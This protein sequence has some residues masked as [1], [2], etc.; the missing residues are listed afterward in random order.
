MC[1]SVFIVDFEQVRAGWEAKGGIDYRI[2]L[3]EFSASKW[4]YWKQSKWYQQKF[5]LIF[6]LKLCLL[7]CFTCLLRKLNQK[8]TVSKETIGFDVW[9]LIF[10]ATILSFIKSRSTTRR[11]IIGY[12]IPRHCSWCTNDS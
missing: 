1:P 8:A 6:L 11:T 4:L 12:S 10:D 3:N 9:C 2:H 7:F 5:L